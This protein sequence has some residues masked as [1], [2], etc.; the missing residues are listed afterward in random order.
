MQIG[1]ILLAH[2]WVTWEQL[3]LAVGDQAD[4]AVRAGRGGSRIRLCSLL[5][6]RGAVDFDHASR[7]LGERH[8]CA[9]VLRRHLERRDRTLADLLPATS[10]RRLCVLPIG[11]LASG[12]LIV[13]ARDPSPALEAALSRA[14]KQDVVIAAAPASYLERLVERTYPT[15]IELP[16]DVAEPISDVYALSDFEI[17]D[18]D[19]ASAFAIE[20]DDDADAFSI[21]DDAAAFAI[22]DAEAL[23][24]FAIDIELHAGAP[25]GETGAPAA[26]TAPPKS[27]AL[28]VAIKARPGSEPARDPLDVL[29]ASFADIDDLEWL[30]DVVMEYVSKRWA[31]AL[32]LA[33]GERRAVGVRGHG[34]RLKPAATRAL[35][36]PLSEPSL[37]QLARDERRVV[38]EPPFDGRRA[39]ADLA[40]VLGDPS[41]AIA[42]PIQTRGATSH[43]L[44]VGDPYAGHNGNAAPDLELLVEA[45]GVVIDRI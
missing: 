12:A 22:E 18:V 42:A 6:S 11:R 45:I 19:D 23:D 14:L 30:F 8:G 17:E 29:I 13:C 33:V 44:V 36:L 27:R 15:D 26:R 4:L 2:G 31:A 28:P 38:D 7:A 16:I 43:V 41:H 32:L 3:V 39:H 9:A 5:V 1:E 37:I 21:E 34:R 10:A 24:D 20:D 35:S 25:G 40:A